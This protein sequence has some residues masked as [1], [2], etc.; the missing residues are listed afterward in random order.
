MDAPGGGEVEG[1]VSAI[2]GLALVGPQA[3]EAGDEDLVA[4]R[5]CESVAGSSPGAR[6]GRC[7]VAGA[8]AAARPQ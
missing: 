1:N 7:R 8:Y 4:G 5:R 6:R 3:N 2:A